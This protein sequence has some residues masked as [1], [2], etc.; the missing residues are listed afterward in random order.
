MVKEPILPMG[1]SGL[2]PTK[3][4]QERNVNN[5]LK[6][7]G[8]KEATDALTAMAK[9][10]KDMWKDIKE[11]VNGLKEFVSFGGTGAV[12]TSFKT[13]IESS[14]SFVIEDKLSVFENTLKTIIGD[15]VDPMLLILN[16]V[17]N[18]LATYIA[19]NDTGAF[20]GAMGGWILGQFIPGGV[21]WTAIGAIIGAAVQDLIEAL[22]K[23]F[24][25]LWDWLFGGEGHGDYTQ[26]PLEPDPYN[27]REEYLAYM[28]EQQRLLEE[29]LQQ[30]VEKMRE[31]QHLFD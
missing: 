20:V 12:I 17:A 24:K 4:L 7:L 1:T 10:E 8:N 27:T 31:Q 5:L 21:I 6:I 29:Y 22:P 9:T 16:T 2:D 18:S 23:V 15:K 3:G 28:E 25:N 19:D 13:E 30:I 26:T 11:S 14:I